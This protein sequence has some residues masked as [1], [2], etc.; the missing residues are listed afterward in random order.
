MRCERVAVSMMVWSSMWPMCRAP[1][2]LGGGMTMEKRGPAA[3][4]LAR[5]MPVSTH[6]LAQCG[7]KRWGSSTLSVLMGENFSLAGRGRETEAG[8]LRRGGGLR[9]GRLVGHD[10]V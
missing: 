1:V 8:R 10:T 7:S 9:R 6:Q 5:K 4:G 2:T 3:P